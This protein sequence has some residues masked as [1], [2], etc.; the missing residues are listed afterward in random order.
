MSLAF[1]RERDYNR[2]RNE[3]MRKGDKK[4]SLRSFSFLKFESIFVERFSKRQS[5]NNYSFYFNTISF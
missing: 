1:S 5:N 4:M 3:D 2:A